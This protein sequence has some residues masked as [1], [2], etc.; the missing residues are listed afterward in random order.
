MA[1]VGDRV[2]FSAN[3]GV[4]GPGLWVSDGTAEGTVLVADLFT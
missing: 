2:F 3:D 4:R 1:A